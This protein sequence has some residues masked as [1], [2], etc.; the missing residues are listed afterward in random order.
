MHSAR[1]NR[2]APEWQIWTALLIVYVVWGS[3]YLAIRVVDETMPP[4]L[5]AGARHVSAGVIIFALLLVTKGP[6]ALRLSRAE[7]FGAGFV[8]L[9]L[10]LGGNGLVMLGERDV[11]SGLA[12]LIIAVVPLFVVLLRRVFGER[13]AS[14][15]YVGVL[16]GFV[17]MAVLIVP[18]GVSGETNV[19][20]MLMLVAASLSW[21]I[22][23]YFSTRLRLPRDPLASTGAQMLVGGTSLAIVGTLAGEWGL[24]QVDRF[25]TDSVVALVYLIVFGSVVAYTAYTWVLQHA[26]VSRVSTYAYV[27][28]VVAI[29]L[30]ALILN[31]TVDVWILLG[32]AIIVIAV[33]LVIRAEAKRAPTEDIVEAEAG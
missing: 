29:V 6:G 33:A 25:S 32:A 22:G 30:G 4:L 12:A 27:N 7:W 10:L 16:G 5:A 2:L 9:A 28:P 14:G 21:A 15:T 23:S 17:G 8:G 20:A 3:T 24:V 19:V 1:P 26:T 13:V 11:P 31:E 18:H